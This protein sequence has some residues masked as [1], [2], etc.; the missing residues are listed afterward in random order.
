MLLTT[1]TALKVDGIAAWVHASHV[2]PADTPLPGIKTDNPLK[3]KIP[4]PPLDKRHHEGA[5]VLPPAW[6]LCGLKLPPTLG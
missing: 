3:L 5:M 4:T 2:K 6:P 1:L